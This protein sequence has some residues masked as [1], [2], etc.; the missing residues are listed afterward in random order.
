MRCHPPS[1]WFE[2][3]AANCE[4]ILLE[5][6]F[7]G[8]CSGLH[9]L[10]AGRDSFERKP[11]RAA[12]EQHARLLEEFAYRARAHQSFLA[13]ATVHGDRAV[14]IIDLASGKRVKTAHKLQLRAAL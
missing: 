9:R 5:N 8:F 3:R 11:I 6:L 2:I 4:L 1:G 10:T 13:V 12:R 7:E 14:F